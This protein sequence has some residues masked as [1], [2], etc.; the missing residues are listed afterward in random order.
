MSVTNQGLSM[1]VGAEPEY[2]YVFEND[3]TG[4]RIRIHARSRDE[5]E[6]QLS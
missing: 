3:E 6:E 5:A 4:E 2:I 1:L